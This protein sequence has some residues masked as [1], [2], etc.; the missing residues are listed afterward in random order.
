M[1][2]A[3]IQGI[4]DSLNDAVVMAECQTPPWEWKSTRVTGTCVAIDLLTS[5]SCTEN[6]RMKN[7]HGFP[8][9]FLITTTNSIGGM[10][11]CKNIQTSELF[12][13]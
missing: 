9:F 8:D 4:Q 6:A 1:T 2:A 10:C 3:F 7:K 12:A 5:L 11:V 13:Q